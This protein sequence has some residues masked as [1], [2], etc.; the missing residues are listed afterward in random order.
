MNNEIYVVTKFA[1][2]TYR[3]SFNDW[4]NTYNESER[5]WYFHSKDKA[6][7][8][9]EKLKTE[10]IAEVATKEVYNIEKGY[11]EP[12]E[13]TYNSEEDCYEYITPQDFDATV[14]FSVDILEFEDDE[15]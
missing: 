9:V 8:F 1:C 12:T 2:E 11:H 3:G 13:V 4:S 14:S 7:A 10:F 5:H 6:E 15:H